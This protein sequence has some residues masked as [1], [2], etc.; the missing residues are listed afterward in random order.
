MGKYGTNL[1][2]FGA[3]EGGVNA[4]NGA[5]LVS[6][7]SIGSNS[8][9]FG[10]S[11]LREIQTG[12]ANGD[13]SSLPNDAGATL[14]DSNPLPYWSF[15]TNSALVT[16]TPTS[17]TSSAS[18]NVMRFNIA[19][20][21]SSSVTASLVRFVPVA[22]SLARSFSYQLETTWLNG[23][24]S[25]SGGGGFNISM[26]FYKNDL[27]TTTGT[28]I[29]STTRNFSAVT[30]LTPYTLAIPDSTSTTGWLNATVPS[31]A[32][33][34][35]ISINIS[36]GA[37]AATTSYVDLVEVRL[38]IGQDGLLLT[39]ITNPSAYSPTV[40]YQ[41]NGY[42]YI[43]NDAA[44]GTAYLALGAGPTFT[45]YGA[46]T[47]NGALDATGNITAAGG[48]IQSKTGSTGTYGAVSVTNSAGSGASLSHDG[49]RATINDALRVA[50]IL[51]ARS[52]T[53]T[54]S[55]VRSMRSDNTYC[56]FYW[57]GSRMQIT[58]PITV[59]GNI[60]AQTLATA[61]AGNIYTIS[62]AAN[63]FSRFTSSRRWKNNIED[64]DAGTLEAA[65]KLKAKHF[66]S[67]HA[68]DQN[69]RLLGFIVEEVAETGLDCAIQYDEDGL[70]YAYDHNVLIAAL[71]VRLEDAE[72]RIA[73]LEA[74]S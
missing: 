27:T 68:V 54:G 5:T 57:D 70:P 39:D 37:T 51:E 28:A 73:E 4:D 31:D 35:R 52:S 66:N 40:I 10:P 19:T 11:A 47:I 9:L 41:S 45:V 8:T 53:T 20:T 30:A 56:G 34:L 61:S 64:A 63:I 55:Q 69:K 44:T 17:S 43:K 72:R 36:N 6:T 21:A 7:N 23:Y 24:A 50:G 67:L 26:Q 58:D 33:Y 15:T 22:G 74:K 16:A 60:T 62:T 65:K 49:T 12:V 42:T 46:T 25:G 1:E 38:N 2:G 3:F 13:F 71:V 18:N 29:T 32:A 14:S 48:V 59:A